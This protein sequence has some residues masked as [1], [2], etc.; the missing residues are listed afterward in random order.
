MLRTHLLGYLET[1]D[2]S[3][4]RRFT[5]ADPLIDD[6]AHEPAEIRLGEAI[7]YSPLLVHRSR[8]NR[9]GRA[10][11]TIQTRFS[12]AAEPEFLRNWFPTPPA[13]ALGWDAPP[14]RADREAA[15][16]AAGDDR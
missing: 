13:S 4:P 6:L 12:D 11:A 15:F 10:R 9:S 2:L 3:N 1:E 14:P 16:A 7:L 8:P 5:I